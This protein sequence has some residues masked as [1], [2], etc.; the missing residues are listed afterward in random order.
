MDAASK[1]IIAGD[2]GC[3]HPDWT[4][5]KIHYE[6]D[7]IS[8]EGWR[9][10]MTDVLASRLFKAQADA[11]RTEVAKAKHE[12]AETQAQL[13]LSRTHRLEEQPTPEEWDVQ[14]LVG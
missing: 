3:F 13:S 8:P 5:W 6:G 9:L 7:L 1:M 11:W 4:G 10:R 12:L 2:L 14:I